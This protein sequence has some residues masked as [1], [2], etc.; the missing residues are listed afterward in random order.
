MAAAPIVPTPTQEEAPIPN[1][2]EEEVAIHSIEQEVQPLEGTRRI[3]RQIIRNP[4]SN[5]PQNQNEENTQIF[6]VEMG[7][8]NSYDAAEIMR[9]ELSNNGEQ[10]I[11][12]LVGNNQSQR[13]RVQIGQFNQYTQAQ[14]TAERLNGLVVP[15]G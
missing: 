3:Q 5:T 14:R 2:G 12:T 15:E 11:I 9:N 8:F 7:R 1:S 13:Y 6:T 10:A 4:I